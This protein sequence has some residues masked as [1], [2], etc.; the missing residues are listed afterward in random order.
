MDA[1]VQESF[2]SYNALQQQ[3]NQVMANHNAAIGAQLLA[4]DMLE[5]A[6]KKA[7]EVPVE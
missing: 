3:M 4:K 1:K 7:S 6:K 2:D 5:E